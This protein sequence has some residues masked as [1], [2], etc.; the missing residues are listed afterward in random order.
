MILTFYGAART[1]TGS[2]HLLEVNG[3]RLL[4]DCGLYQGKRKIAFVKNRSLPFQP[5][6]IHNVIL[7]TLTSTT[8]EICRS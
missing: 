4:L 2:M 1:V 3:V 5:S 6:E 7:S 8:R